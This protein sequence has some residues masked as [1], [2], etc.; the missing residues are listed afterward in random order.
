ARGRAPARRA[1]TAGPGRWVPPTRAGRRRTERHSSPRSPGAVASTPRAAR[2]RGRGA[3]GPR[4]RE[5]FGQPATTRYDIPEAV[6][7]CRTPGVAITRFGRGACWYGACVADMAAAISRPESSSASPSRSTEV[8]AEQEEVGDE[9]EESLVVRP[10]RAVD[11]GAP[12]RV[13]PC[14]EAGTDREN[15]GARCAAADDDRRYLGSRR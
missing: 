5:G 13:G 3:P 14:P 6:S 9:S 7:K 4:H 8:R 12:R 10:G 1:P 2:Q 15:P 11:G